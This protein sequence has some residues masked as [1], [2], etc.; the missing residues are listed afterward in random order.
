MPFTTLSSTKT[1][2]AD[3]IATRAAIQNGGTTA[4]AQAQ[5]AIDAAQ[6]PACAQVFARTDFDRLRAAATAPA[7]A[8]PVQRPL[9]GLSV[10]IKD[11]FDI[12]G[13]PT[14]AGSRVLADAPPTATD[15]VAVARLRAAGAGL[16]GRTNM[17]EF[18]FSGI[19]INPHYGTPAAWDG[20]Y[21]RQAGAV[22]NGARV[23]GGSSSGA[24]V[25]VATGAAFIGLG[26]D[27]GGSIRIP[28]AL[29]GI[30]GFK[31]TAARVPTVGALPLSTTMDTVCALT[32]SVRDGILAHE[33]LAARRVVRSPSPL[34]AYRLAVVDTLM[35]DDLD[36]LVARVFERTLRRLR[37]LGA[38]IEVIPLTELSEL[39]AINATGGFSPVESYAWHRHLLAQH[40][41]QYDPRVRARIERGAGMTAYEYLDL[42]KARRD[43]MARIEARLQPIDAVLSPTVPI[44]S[45]RYADVAPGAERDAA[46]FKAN[47]LL[48][49]NTSAINVL[50]GCGISIPCH[51][52]DE[53]PVG[54]MIWH[55]AE[56][57]DT[58]L[59]VALQAEAALATSASMAASGR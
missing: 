18:A 31:C 27:T 2:V 13:E 9:A 41:A 3:L 34:S 50:D 29:N 6:S 32:R 59:N 48:L 4:L 42:I 39:G 25:S 35:Q 33:V 47:G 20:R 21:G 53:M 44:P 58:V 22:S 46:F 30:V 52:A 37:S 24:G 23:P 7:N 54:L 16:I 38:R 57:D 45:P 28:A 19:G 49:R 15:C 40:G 55:A 10:S 36:P 56:H 8:N 51:N 1:P 17:V 26:S 43:W 5:Q 14:L 11:L 12:Q